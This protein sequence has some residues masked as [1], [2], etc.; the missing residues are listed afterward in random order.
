[1]TA[2]QDVLLDELRLLVEQRN[3]GAV[4]PEEFELRAAQLLKDPPA[5]GRA[6]ATTT[7]LEAPL[8][9]PSRSDGRSPAGGFSAAPAP[10]SAPAT[11]VL[12]VAP[13]GP[14]RWSAG[15]TAPAT[16]TSNGGAA[17]GAEP[18]PTPS[19]PPPRPA[20]PSPFS[21]A[22][23]GFTA[24]PEPQA[25]SASGLFT[26]VPAASR[27][28]SSAAQV[29]TFAA[30]PEIPPA[31]TTASAH[32]NGTLSAAPAVQVAPVPPETAVEKVTEKRR[33]MRLSR[34][35][36]H[37][38]SGRSRSA[39]TSP[40]VPL[41]EQP[42]PS[43]SVWEAAPA[44]SMWNAAPIAPPDEPELVTEALEGS[45]SEAPTALT[46]LESAAVEPDV[47]VRASTIDSIGA[48]A[49][50]EIEADPTG[51]LFL[52]PAMAVE[53]P[54]APAVSDEPGEAA[55][56]ALV[57]EPPPAAVVAPDDPDIGLL[58]E[59]VLY[60]PADEAEE[61]TAPSS[62]AASAAPATPR[63][64]RQRGL[65]AGSYWDLSE[66]ILPPD[67]P[68]GDGAT[69]PAATMEGTYWDLSRR[70]LAEADR[71]IE[72]DDPA[73]VQPG[74]YWDRSTIQR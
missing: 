34:R 64:E 48:E 50:A 53:V 22:P 36:R 56:V 40:A 29:P 74:G 28:A 1:M 7:P 41:D 13:V 8:G 5:A 30:T 37:S 20:T 26:A 14:R 11:D 45:S 54:S 4:T 62:P 68:C 51:E 70:I 72:E 38:T 57:E 18:V 35:G 69:D 27:T 31:P 19:P 63:V 9:P 42:T 67:A 73:G 25:T 39:A 52:E 71:R 16:P 43:P 46:D 65:I 59:A 61:E 17:A 3:S 49:D 33:R 58:A 12:A 66:R 60:L 15:P 23:S 47:V 6:P 44:P 55:Q 21:A 10:G 24:T 32:S 2:G